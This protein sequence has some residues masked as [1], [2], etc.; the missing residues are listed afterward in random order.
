MVKSQSGPLALDDL[1]F[2]IVRVLSEDPDLTNRAI[3]SALEIAESTCAYRVR[4]LRDAAVI[5]PRRLEVDHAA[6]GYSLTAVVTVY[7]ASHSREVVNHFMNIIAET[8]NVL[9]VMNTTGRYD[10]L[11]VVAVT[12]SEQLR[13]FVLDHVTVIPAVRSTETHIVF[14]RRIGTW[15]PGPV[16][17]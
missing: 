5:R 7:L 3:A 10:F 15:T 9:Q 14:D 12:D 4:R 13:S 6:L 8:P 16:D 1:D 11:I 2:E 17:S